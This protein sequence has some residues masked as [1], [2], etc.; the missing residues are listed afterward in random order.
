MREDLAAPL[1]VSWIRHDGGVN[2][3]AIQK[4]ASQPDVGH[5]AAGSREDGMCSRWGLIFVPASQNAV[6]LP[7]E[8]DAETFLLESPIMPCNLDKRVILIFHC[9]FS[10]ERGPRM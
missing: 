6:N 3:P 10:S 1:V 2:A 4:G 5:S 7:L 9:E 8:K